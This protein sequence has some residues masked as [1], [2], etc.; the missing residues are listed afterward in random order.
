MQD[1]INKPRVFLSHSKVDID[2]IN[3]IYYDLLKCQ[4]DPW[5][6]SEEIRH[7][8]PWLEAI[9]EHGLPKCDCI[10]VYFTES[11]LNSKMVKKEIDSGIIQKLTDSGVS[12]LPYVSNK[13]IRESLRIDIQALQTPEWNESNYH[14]LL[15]RVVAE[16]W[17]SYLERVVSVVTQNEKVKRLEAEIQLE[18]I[19]NREKKIFSDSE[20]TEFNHILNVFSRV[21]E[22]I[23]EEEFIDSYGEKL[24]NKYNLGI[25][26]ASLIPLIADD[27][28]YS[29]SAAEKTIH[30]SLSSD[31]IENKGKEWKIKRIELSIDPRDELFLFG[32]LQRTVNHVETENPFLRRMMPRY[33][34]VFTEKM[35]RF[36]YWLSFKKIL[37]QKIEI[38][39]SE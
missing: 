5:K 18:K 28:E 32:L 33:I 26:L 7:G 9:F 19:R 8:K 29:K 3:R 38:I 14:E 2:F 37:P 39:N 6:D 36:R 1:S 11:S 31:I 25:N 23:V 27:Y 16:I 21:E 22:I 4:I 13:K 17:R 34:F 12:F 35:Q 10:L 30:D 20:E 15:P 24:S